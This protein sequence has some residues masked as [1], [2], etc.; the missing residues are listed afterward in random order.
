MRNATMLFENAKDGKVK[1]VRGRLS[2]KGNRW[3][4]VEVKIGKHT[5]KSDELYTVSEAIELTQF[6]IRVNIDPVQPKK[7]V[8][9]DPASWKQTTMIVPQKAEAPAPEPAKA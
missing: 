2:G 3:N 6:G 1:F 9:V 7:I 5:F 8:T 4:D